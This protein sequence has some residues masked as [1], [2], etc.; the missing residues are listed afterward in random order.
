[1][2]G[3]KI[4]SAA[5]VGLGTLL[6]ASTSHAAPDDRDLIL[7]PMEGGYMHNFGAYRGRP[8]QSLGTLGSGFGYMWD[9]VG[10]M[11][12]ARVGMGPGGTRLG[13][14]GGRG[15]YSLL[16]NDLF[17]LGPDLSITAGGGKVDGKR[18]GLIA[19]AEP[20]ISARAYS[21]MAGMFELKANWYQP[22]SNDQ[23]WGSGAMLSLSWHPIYTIW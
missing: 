19:A 17:E 3:T 4:I 20:G 8:N 6:Y 15:Y 13:W 2:S 7:V 16:G 1:M 14:G 5:A 23:S 21:E 18:G 12:I 11:A 10:F 9:R 22:L